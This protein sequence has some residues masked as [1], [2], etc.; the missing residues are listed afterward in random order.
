MI[1]GQK[2]KEIR[3]KYAEMGLRKF[4]GAIDMKASELSN[5][6]QGYAPYPDDE[7]FGRMHHACGTIINDD[8]SELVRLR[9]QPFVMQKMGEEGMIFH[10]T[11]RIQE[12]EEGY[13]SEED[14][15]DTRPATPEECVGIS[16]WFNN[17]A[18][19]HNEKADEY[20]AKHKE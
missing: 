3:L 2:L 15:Y 20:N 9:E 11:K 10:A 14:D 7:I 17:R 5:I 8:W 13:T 12:G 4:S 1:F 6:E 18:R 16:E 19:E